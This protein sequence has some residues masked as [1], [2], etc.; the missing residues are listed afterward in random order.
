M[1][2]AP[3]ADQ[4]RLLDVQDADTRIAQATHRRAHLP[5]LAQVEE[6]RARHADLDTARTLL[7]V[8]VTDIKREVAKAEDDVLAV[9]ARADRDTLR[10]NSGDGSVRDLQALQG[11]L[12]VLAKRRVDLEDVELEAMA[13]LED[14]ENRLAST[15]TQ[16]EAIAAQIAELE[17]TVAAEQEAIDRELADLAADRHH[18][19]AG[20]DAGLV[21]LYERLRVQGGGVGA[22]ALVGGQCQGCHMTLNAADLSRIHAAAEDEVVRCEEC[23]RILVRGAAA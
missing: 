18:A 5:I 12:E 4:H 17:A 22:A 21:A 2:Q 13:R 3:A 23:G 16:V 14:A 9:R 7:A 11:E 1:A 8:E 15:R 10:L 19:V 20:L 6:L